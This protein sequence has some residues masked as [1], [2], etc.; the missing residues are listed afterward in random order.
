M[1]TALSSPVKAEGDTEGVFTQLKMFWWLYAF[2]GG[3]AV[4]FAGVLALARGLMGTIF[5]DPVMLVFLSLLLGF[6]VLGNGLLLGLAC[7]FAVQRRLGHWGLFLSE[8]VFAIA[9]G[10]YIAVSLLMTSQ[11][12]ASLAGLHALG[13]GVFQCVMA[14]RLKNELPYRFLLGSSGSIS[15]LAGALFLTHLRAEPYLI[16]HW[17]SGFEFFYGMVMIVF[18]FQMHRRAAVA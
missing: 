3:F 12:L 6:Y 2:R 1:Q 7:G 9:L 4:L 16:T 15:L 10:V 17:L 11:S 13:A 14:I 5:F 8:S 18:A